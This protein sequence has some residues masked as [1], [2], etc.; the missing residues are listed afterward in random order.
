M[1]SS[2]G[3]SSIGDVAHKFDLDTHVLRHWESVGLL[4]PAR[5]SADRRLYSES[6][7]VRVAVIVRNKA[8]G[9][10]LPQIAVLLDADSYQRHK[11]L[12]E[13]IA[14]L[15]HRMEEMRLSREMTY[16]SLHC[17]QHDIVNCPRFRASLE[18]LL[19]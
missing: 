8:A 9:M 18:D 4:S 16:H 11:I 10:S 19:V 12:A 15:D 6:D 2:C 7:I 17:E 5:D 13:H 14:D 3:L 1:K